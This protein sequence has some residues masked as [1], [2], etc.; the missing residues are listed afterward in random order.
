M[1]RLSY[2]NETFDIVWAGGSVH[3]TSN[4]LKAIEELIRVLRRGSI[5]LLAVY[6][7]TKF[8]FFHE[9]IRKILVRTPQKSRTILSKI[10]ALFL[11][12]ITTFWR[13]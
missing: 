11:Q 9:L 4:P 1:L 12:N 10:L 2:K 3:H 5:L 7:K 6:N 13:K 8:T